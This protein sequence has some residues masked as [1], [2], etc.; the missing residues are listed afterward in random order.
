MDI[1]KH[2]CLFSSIINSKNLNLKSNFNAQRNNAFRKVCFAFYS[3]DNGLKCM[4][5]GPPATILMCLDRYFNRQQF[6][7][8]HQKYSL[9]VKRLKNDS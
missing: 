7:L 9:G 2:I 5:F 1:N 4:A 3:K 6:S 8:G